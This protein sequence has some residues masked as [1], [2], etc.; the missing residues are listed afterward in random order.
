MRQW[1]ISPTIVNVINKK[2]G[3]SKLWE[4]SGL[5]PIIG[6]T[7]ILCL[8]TLDIVNTIAQPKSFTDDPFIDDEKFTE[9]GKKYIY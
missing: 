4:M 5:F 7:L 8:N 3:K 1:D 6:L 9:K 2:R